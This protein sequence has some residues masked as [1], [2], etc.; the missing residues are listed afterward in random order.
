M[1]MEAEMEA[2]VNV[3]MADKIIFKLIVAQ[4]KR[5]SHS[6]RGSRLFAILNMH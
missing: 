5:F 2:F 3:W 1:F 4:A 6:R